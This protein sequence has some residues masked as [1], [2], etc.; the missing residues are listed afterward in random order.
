MNKKPGLV[1]DNRYFHHRISE[2]SLENPERLRNL[3]R[4]L[5]STEYQNL[6]IKVPPRMAVTD[7]IES[8]HSSFYV[9][10]LRGHA[11]RTDP[12]SYDRD[13]YLMEETLPTAELAV[14]GC[15]ELADKIMAEEINYGFAL[16]RPPGHHAEP[17]RGMGFCVFNNVALTAK[18]LLDTYKL[19]RIL[20]VDFDIH[21][22][23]GTQE[24]FYDSDQV[25]FL[26]LHQSSLFP[27]TGKESETGEEDGRGYTIN[28]L[29]FSQFGD[30]EY[31]YLLGHLL[32]NLV[33]QY[34]PQVIL[35][36]AGYD[37]HIDESISSTLLSTKWF[38]VAT[39]M[40]RQ[41]AREV[42]D[43]KLLFILEGGYNP[44]SLEASIL[45]TFNSLITKEIPQTGIFPVKRAEKLL[46]QHPLREFWSI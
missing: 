46:A 27:F 31:T 13:T 10:Q 9:N 32:Q 20:I 1:F 30:P 15:L 42:C 26:S 38:G 35:V 6:F 3:Y 19:R 7:E 39:A 44:V 23:N 2:S 28:V 17:G 43:N 25:M 40:L 11:L 45:E 22:G 16:I 29:V 14:G 36:S 33:E 5:D 37:G 8:L 21:H 24:A 12:F 41:A 34:Q 4:T 18:Y